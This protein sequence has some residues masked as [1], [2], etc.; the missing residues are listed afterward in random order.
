MDWRRWA[1]GLM[2]L[3]CT[4]TG[5]AC[6]ASV[7]NLTDKDIDKIDKLSGIAQSWGPE[8]SLR[9]RAGRPFLAALVEGVL[10]IPGLEIDMDASADPARRTRSPVKTETDP[11]T[12]TRPVEPSIDVSRV[13]LEPLDPAEE[14]TVVVKKGKVEKRLIFKGDQLVFSE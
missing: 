3:L 12:T 2:L 11:Q 6:S 7:G 13:P 14:H 5:L 1:I 9:I 8:G 4:T 10:V